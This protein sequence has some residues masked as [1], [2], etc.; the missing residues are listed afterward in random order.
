MKQKKRQKIHTADFEL[1]ISE[2][3]KDGTFTGYGSVFNVVDQGLDIVMPGAFADSLKEISDSG[4]KIPV[5]WQ[6][7]YDSPIGV[8]EKIEEDDT[9]LLVEGRLL[10]DDVQLAKEAFSLMDAGAV[11][12]LSIGYGTQ[13]SELDEKTRIRKLHELDLYEISLVTFPMND[14]ARVE[15]VKNLIH[16]GFLPESV[17]DFE[18]F[19]RDAGFSKKNATEIATRGIKGLLR[20]DSETKEDLAD[21]GSILS[22]FKLN[23]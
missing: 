16:H 8:Y 17:R 2:V 22:S 19:L 15:S 6:H 14:E 13:R 12:G 18:K 10:V 21:I 9:G 3:K 5:L 11:T 20:S 23:I 7:R 4:R 1:K